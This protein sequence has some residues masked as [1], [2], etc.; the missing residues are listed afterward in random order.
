MKV[1]YN[2]DHPAKFHLFKNAMKM[3]KDRGNEV[4]LTIVDKEVTLNLA[5]KF[6]K[7]YDIPYIIIGLNS[8]NLSKKAFNVPSI[9]FNLLKTALNFKPDLLIGGDGDIYVS[10]VSKL[11]NK[12]SFVFDETEHAKLQNSIAYPFTSKIFTPD[13]YEKNL[14]KKQIKY[15]G[16]H[17]LAYLHPDI[18]NPRKEVLEQMNLS[19]NDKITIIRL[20]SWDAFHD[21]GKRGMI[22]EIESLLKKLS[23]YTEV[24]INSENKLPKNLEKYQLNVNPEDLHDILYYSSIY[25]GEGATTAAESAVLGTPAIYTNPLKMGYTNELE[26][27][28]SLLYNMPTENYTSI[29][30]KSLELISNNNLKNESSKKIK[31]LLNEKINV[32]TYIVD[33]IENYNKFW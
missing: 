27:R 17:E 6:C 31:R 21:I 4:L 5:E 13:C 11:L 8:G 9:E 28:Y 3:L 20:V 23:D 10:H 32:T 15:N 24:I 1:L 25:I 14:G 7:I 33:V 30:N 18:F 26:H 29:L 2:V 16:Y 12:P 19:K 22:S